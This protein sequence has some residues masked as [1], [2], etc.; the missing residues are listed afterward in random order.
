MI[1]AI[2]VGGSLALSA[3]VASAS[4]LGSFGSD[5]NS[6]DIT[7]SFMFSG[8]G[9]EDFTLMLAKGHYDLDLAAL[10]KTSLTGTINSVTFDGASPFTFSGMYVATNYLFSVAADDTLVS[11]DVVGSSSGLSFGS[12]HVPATQPSYLGLFMLTDIGEVQP[13]ATAVSEPWNIALLLAGLG[14]ISVM[15]KRKTASV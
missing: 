8:T 7:Q 5:T 10:L 14:L 3:L 9:S 11:F 12:F 6:S 4:S 2:I 13:Q 15:Y 1:R